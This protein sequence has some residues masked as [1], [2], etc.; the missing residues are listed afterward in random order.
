MCFW[1]HLCGCLCVW[2]YT[3]MKVTVCMCCQIYKVNIIVMM[4]H[5]KREREVLPECRRWLLSPDA[6]L[7]IQ[8]TSWHTGASRFQASPVSEP[9]HTDMCHCTQVSC[10]CWGSKPSSSRLCGRHFRNSLVFKK[11]I[12]FIVLLCKLFFTCSWPFL[13]KSRDFEYHSMEDLQIQF[14]FNHCLSV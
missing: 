5:N 2:G 7:S 13:L 3:C 4:S 11:L 9:W 6:W 8:L 14:C 1:E 12:S 10:A